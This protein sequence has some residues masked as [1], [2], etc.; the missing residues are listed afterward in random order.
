MCHQE[1]RKS[2]YSTVDILIKHVRYS[3]KC[4]VRKGLEIVVNI[5]MYFF[6]SLYPGL[7]EYSIAQ[8]AE[9][10]MIQSFIY[11]FSSAYAPLPFHFCGGKR[12]GQTFVT[13]G[14]MD[15]MKTTCLQQKRG[16]V[17]K[18]SNGCV[19]KSSNSSSK[20]HSF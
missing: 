3:V 7:T 5:Y 4:F 6:V 16:C 19:S 10:F 12:R 2:S 13:D 14:Q 15:R 20:S 1:N 11:I 17:S 9:K 8:C 18:S